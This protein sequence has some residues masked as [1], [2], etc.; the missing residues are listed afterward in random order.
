MRRAC[1]SRVSDLEC[2]NYPGKCLL[3]TTIV[4]AHSGVSLRFSNSLL[5]LNVPCLPPDRQSAVCTRHTVWLTAQTTAAQRAVEWLRRCTAVAD[6]LGVF[7][8]NEEL[9]DVA[10]GDLRLL[11][12]PKL[13]ADLLARTPLR[14]PLER[15]A[16]L[17]QAAAEYSRCGH[18]RAGG[19]ARRPPGAPGPRLAGRG[20]CCIWV[21]R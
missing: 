17:K 2:C 21:A 12:V 4:C 8:R 20:A 5:L 11:L 1:T 3:C 19:E 16:Q 14:E 10:T 15:A 9:D 7:S 18:A 13:L 6:A